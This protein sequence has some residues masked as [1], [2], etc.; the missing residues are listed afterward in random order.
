MPVPKRKATKSK[1]GLRKA[2]KAKKQFTLSKCP[3]CGFPKLP[4]RVCDNCG[5]Y[6][7]KQVFEFEEEQI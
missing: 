4:H 6:G 7:E 2:G 3:E 5:F 1:K